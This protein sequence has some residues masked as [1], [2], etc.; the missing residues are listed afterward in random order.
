MDPG[1][2]VRIRPAA[3]EDFA[4]IAAI[5]NHYIATTAIH[6]GYQPVTADELAAAWQAA[7][8]RYPWLVAADAGAVIGYAKAGEWRARDA[9][10]WTAEIG[11]YVAADRRGAGTGRALYAALIEALAAAGFRSAIGGITLPNPA[12]IALH[13]RLG[14]THVGTVRDAGYKLGAWHDVAFYQRR[15]AEGPAGPPGHSSSG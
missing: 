1:M 7:T 15:L 5:T 2:A 9:Y 6:F 3:A 11:V 12:S 4:A 13:E 10:R 8:G 14:F